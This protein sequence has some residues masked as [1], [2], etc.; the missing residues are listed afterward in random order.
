MVLVTSK[1]FLFLFLFFIATLRSFG[2]QPAELKTARHHAMKYYVSLPSGFTKEK[3]WP[4]LLVLESAAK[5]FEKNANRFVEARGDLPFIIVAPINTNNGNQGRRDP[6][7]F[8]YSKDTWDYIEKVGDCQ[9]NL[10]GIGE[11]LKDIEAE[12]NAEA[13]VYATGFEAGT[14]D[15][16]SLVFNRPEYLYAAAPVAGNF[17]NRCTNG[18]SNLSDTQKEK[19]P[20]MSFIGDKDE[21]FGAGSNFYNQ[22]LEAK[23][24]AIAH[25]FKNI[26][27]TVL[28]GVGH[29]PIP[30]Q[31]MQYFHALRTGTK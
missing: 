31:V 14:H 13:K 1:R 24:F 4:V 3:K 15:L 6:A 29:E 30:K 26:S 9:F 11:I 25:G 10:D 21:G 12:Y 5:E 16:W 23:A 27:E 7:V 17:R 2:Q 8:P 28:Q 20:I 18:V 19:L 22:W